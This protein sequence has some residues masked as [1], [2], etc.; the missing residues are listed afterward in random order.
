MQ[1][2]YILVGAPGSG[3]SWISRQLGHKF[4]YVPHDI[5]GLKGFSDYVKE[6]VKAAQRSDKPVLC[7]T[8]TSLS[9]IQGP[10]EFQ[11]LKVHPVFVIE[12]PE[13]TRTRYEARDKKPIP[14]G[15]I[16]RI[17]TYL[18]RSKQLNAPRGTSDE[19]LAY[20]KDLKV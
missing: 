16:T 14:K 18:E 1:D 15:H 2:V 20:L 13:V 10:L 17:E 9:Q 7:D 6:I 11:G 12:T 19:I 3:K 4:N 5:F 8:P